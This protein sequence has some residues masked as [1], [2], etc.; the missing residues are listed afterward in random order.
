MA[1]AVREHPGARPEPLG[2]P[3]VEEVRAARPPMAVVEAVAAS[4]GESAVSEQSFERLV[5][6]MERFAYFLDGGFGI[7]DLHE[8]TGE[9]VQQFVLSGT[10]LGRPPSPTVMHLRRCAVRMLFRVA[11]ELGMVDNDP[12]VDL[13][14]PSRPSAAPRALTDE[15]V[16]LCRALSIDHLHATRL[17][18]AWALAEAGVRTGELANVTVGHLDVASSRVWVAGC[19]SAAPRCAELTEWGAVQLR[20]RLLAIPTRADQPLIYTADGSDKSRQAASCIALSMTLARAGL[21]DDPGIRPI[22]VTAWVGRKVMERTGRVEDVAMA[23]GMR[24]L[25]RAARLIGYEWS[26]AGGR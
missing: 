18:A 15:E 23:L 16:A 4:I 22:S 6:L 21:G 2:G 5:D 9:L 25:D 11:R 20:R 10:A 17:S 19:K 8:V 12:T 1:P 26:A 13:R 24:S 7:G 14:L 3:D